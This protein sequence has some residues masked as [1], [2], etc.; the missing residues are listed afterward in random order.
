MENES[1]NVKD[2]LM[3]QIDKL[4]EIKMSL[5]DMQDLIRSLRDYIPKGLPKKEIKFFENSF[6]YY[7][8]GVTAQKINGIYYMVNTSVK[9]LNKFIS[10]I[11][12]K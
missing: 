7:I 1:A 5:K 9:E 3:S 12:E 10:G 6:Q 4:E 11:K 8:K 2:G